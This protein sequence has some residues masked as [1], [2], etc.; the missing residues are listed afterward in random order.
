MVK[1]L[2]DAAHERAEALD[3]LILREADQQL[4]AVDAGDVVVLE[5]S[6]AALTL[7]ALARV[8]D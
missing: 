7:H 4:T 6:S 3:R 5:D 1:N 8:L 2:I